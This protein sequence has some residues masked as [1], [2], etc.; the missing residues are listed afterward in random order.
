MQN[1]NI[2][3]DDLMISNLYST[4]ISEAFGFLN[5]RL[6]LFILAGILIC[7]FIFS[8]KIKEQNFK[9]HLKILGFGVLFLALGFA[10]FLNPDVKDFF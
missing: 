1:F 2:I 3:I 6:C 5:F 7:V 9:A 4:D 8:L 10:N